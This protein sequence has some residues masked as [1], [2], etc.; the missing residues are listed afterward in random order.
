MVSRPIAA[1]DPSI[2]RWMT[3]NGTALLEHRVSS[4]VRRIVGMVGGVDY[5]KG[6]SHSF[7]SPSPS[8][9]Q[10]RAVATINDDAMGADIVVPGVSGVLTY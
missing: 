3:A 9:R 2:V 1:C 6:L 7:T 4:D 8:D 10:P 5:D